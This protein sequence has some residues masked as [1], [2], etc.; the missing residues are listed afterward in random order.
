VSAL[1]NEH[2]V[3]CNDRLGNPDGTGLVPLSRRAVL[4]IENNESTVGCR[5]SRAIV[6]WI[7]SAGIPPTSSFVVDE[8]Y[9]R[10]IRSDLVDT[11]SGL[12]R[13]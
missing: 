10:L 5:P 1:R 8:D 3:L 7:L 11:V 6:E 2:R 4:V 9:N 12:A 13:N